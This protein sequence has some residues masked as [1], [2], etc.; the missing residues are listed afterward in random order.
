VGVSLRVKWAAALVVVAALPLGSFGYRS[1][2]LQ[3][4]G[5]L[6]AERQLEVSV[7]DHASTLVEQ[8][9][10]GAAE[11]THRV[12]QLLT[13]ASIQDEDA[14]LGLA[15][16]TVARADVLALVAIYSPDGQLLDGIARTGATKVTAPAHLQPA[17]LADARTRWLGGSGASGAGQEPVRYLEAVDRDGKRRAWFVGFLDVPSL[18]ARLQGISRDRFEGRPDGVLLLDGGVRVLAGTGGGALA[19]GQ[20]LAGRDLLR[21]ADLGP[22]PFARDFALTT[23]FAAD[24]GEAMSG[25]V[26]A[27]PDLGWAVAVRRSRAAAYAQLAES[28]RALAIS[29]GIF[30]ALAVLAGLLIAGW[31][32]RP[33]ARLVELTRAYSKRRFAD[34]STVHT[35][36]ELEALGRSMEQMAD[37]I[38]AGEV[39]IARRARVQADLSRYLPAAVATSIADGKATLALGGERRQ[40]S[41]VFADVCAFTTFA[42]RA[43][44]EHV[45][46]FLNELFSVLTE[47]VFRHGGTVDKFVGDCIM[48]VFGAPAAQEDH[49]ARA[50]SAAEDM[51][52]F[53]EASAPAWKEAHGID[54]QLGV[55][56]SSGEAVVGNLGSETRMEYTAIGDV[57]NIAARLEQL[58]RPG[59]TLMT[60]E[61]VE[62]AG[63]GF[64]AMPL[65][66][67]PLRGK[68]QPVK[69]FELR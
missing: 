22:D 32:T 51:H 14:R 24:D 7:V 36:D 45:V 12:G 9:T 69:I 58:A 25:T 38:A 29:A 35:G 18:G 23:E 2:Q 52:R 8:S 16:D 53:V 44:P 37:G 50:L 56:V 27:L 41:V 3:R 54:V 34:R 49:A 43:P 33:V 48:A 15:R 5:L 62:R 26:R 11:A 20:V 66:E 64:P 17:E 47:V 59:Q 61:V 31:T 6:D 19:P 40:I 67:H 65:G 1:A 42:E 21:G 13:E 39:E 4:Q 60:A 63:E 68:K 10:S 28:R 55:G 46:A 30:V 57:V